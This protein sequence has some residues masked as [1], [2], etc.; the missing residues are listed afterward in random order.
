MLLFKLNESKKVFLIK[1]FSCLFKAS[2]II[3][4][5]LKHK[6]KILLYKEKKIIKESSKFR[7][8]INEY[9]LKSLKL[10]P[11]VE[12]RS[13]TITEDEVFIEN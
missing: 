7:S 12:G 5:T 10:A 9:E 1:Y 3:T 4:K 2:L 6:R 8:R 13:I 11:Q